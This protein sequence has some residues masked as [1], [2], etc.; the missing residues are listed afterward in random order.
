MLVDQEEMRRQASLWV[1]LAIAGI[2][3]VC[4]V[5]MRGECLIAPV[6]LG[7]S[8]PNI[9]DRKVTLVFLALVIVLAV[10]LILPSLPGH[11]FLSYR[12]AP[13]TAW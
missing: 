8:L 13:L 4:R 10:R 5:N 7:T 6:A 9:S 1:A 2:T 11:H 3:L 12:G